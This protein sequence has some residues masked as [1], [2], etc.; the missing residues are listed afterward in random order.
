MAKLLNLL[1]II[2]I[3]FFVYWSLKN[4]FRNKK[5]KQ[6]GI[7]IKQTKVR[8]ITLFSIVMLVMYASYMIYHLLYL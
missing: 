3:L 1:T 2:G 6:Q 5:L 8:P 4:H 7:Q